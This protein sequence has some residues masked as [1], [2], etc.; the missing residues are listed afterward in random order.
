[1]GCCMSHK[2]MPHAARYAAVR[3]EGSTTRARSRAAARL[4]RKFIGVYATATWS[5]ATE[6]ARSGEG[7]PRAPGGAC[8]ARATARIAHREREL[9]CLDVLQR[10]RD[11]STRKVRR[12]R[13]RN[14]S[15]RPELLRKVSAHRRVCNAPIA[16]ARTRAPTR[17]ARAAGVVR[18]SGRSG[19]GC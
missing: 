10:G 12:S 3:A 13:R 11:V 5:N 17:H 4:P 15:R 6:D 8:S 7:E 9:A 19:T 18:P 14:R 2:I 1:M 16:L